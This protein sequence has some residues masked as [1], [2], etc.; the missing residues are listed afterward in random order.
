MQAQVV[1]HAGASGSAYRCLQKHDE[2]DG[3]VS[4]RG[5]GASSPALVKRKWPGT[6]DYEL[7]LITHLLSDLWA[8]WIANT[9]S[10]TLAT[11]ATTTSVPVCTIT[12][13]TPGAH[14]LRHSG[15]CPFTPT[16]G[17]LITLIRR[18]RIG[19]TVM[20]SAI[21]SFGRPLQRPIGIDRSLDVTNMTRKRWQEIWPRDVLPWSEWRTLLSMKERSLRPW[22]SSSMMYVTRNWPWASLAAQII[23]NRRMRS[24]HTWWNWLGTRGTI[25]SDCQP[26]YQRR[27][28]CWT[29]PTPGT[30][31]TTMPDMAVMPEAAVMRVEQLPRKQWCRTQHRRQCQKALIRKCIRWLKETFW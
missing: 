18:R 7:L 25:L 13:K 23:E 14:W 21:A 8:S 22:D 20:S 16:S 30:S 5:E 3:N 2:P 1:V 9:P 6:S 24:W 19:S 10:S 12:L 17:S 4:S 29:P 26:A 27:N 28:R 11:M 15:I 31:M